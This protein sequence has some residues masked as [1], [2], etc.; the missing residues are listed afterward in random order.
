MYVFYVFMD[1]ITNRYVPYFYYQQPSYKQSYQIS[2]LLS[3]YL[4]KEN[5]NDFTKFLHPRCF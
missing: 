5:I 3:Y 2:L 4:L 1:D